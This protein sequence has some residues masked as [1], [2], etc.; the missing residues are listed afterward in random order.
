MGR[1]RK[2]NGVAVGVTGK[3]KPPFGG[4]NLGVWRRA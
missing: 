4:S 1:A 2:L 3:K